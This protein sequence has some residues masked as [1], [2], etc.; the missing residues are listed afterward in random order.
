MEYAQVIKKND[1]LIDLIDH[2][3]MSYIS[4]DNKFETRAVVKYFIDGHRSDA[5]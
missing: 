4:F 3:R 2:I 5:Y 1:Y